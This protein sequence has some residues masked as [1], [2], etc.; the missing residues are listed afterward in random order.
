M[1]DSATRADRAAAKAASVVANRAIRRLDIL[2][3]LILF[4]AMLLATGGGAVVA[5]LIAPTLP[6]QFRTTWIGT[7][8]LLFVL[9]GTFALA[10][11][12][13][14][15]REAQ[16]TTHQTTDQTDGQS[17]H[18]RTNRG[19]TKHLHGQSFS[20]TVI[21]SARVRGGTIRHSV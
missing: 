1:S 17:K 19:R 13:R 18:Q 6:F 16:S 4:G 8:I 11:L 20:V 14:S 9:P 15:E 2:E 7:S 10:R 5:W 12:R 21:A 3:W